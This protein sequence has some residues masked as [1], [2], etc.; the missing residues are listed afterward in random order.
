MSRLRTG[1]VVV[2]RAARL[3]P[4]LLAPSRNLNLGDAN[5]DPLSRHQSDG[6]SSEDEQAHSLAA[7][8]KPR[9]SAPSDLLA[10]SKALTFLYCIL[11]ISLGLHSPDTDTRLPA[12]SKICSMP[13]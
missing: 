12:D 1:V 9:S 7:I 5:M 2:R 10:L 4:R 8:A 13:A 3:K 6:G 11:S